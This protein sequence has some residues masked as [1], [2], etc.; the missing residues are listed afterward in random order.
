MRC[1]P[2]AKRLARL[3]PALAALWS[4]AGFVDVYLPPHAG[5]VRIHSDQP[6]TAVRFVQRGA[7]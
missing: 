3:P 7:Q 1:L 4:A 2:A 5:Q 6:I